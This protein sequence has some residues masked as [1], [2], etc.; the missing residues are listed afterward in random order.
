MEREV[1]GVIDFDELKA[2]KEGLITVKSLLSNSLERSDEFEQVVLIVLDKEGYVNVGHS[3]GDSLL[4]LLG[5]IEAG[6]NQI[7]YELE[8]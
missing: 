7:I 4:K 5:L 1:C 3:E 2:K 8:P 6:K